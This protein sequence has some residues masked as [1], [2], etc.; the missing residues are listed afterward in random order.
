MSDSFVLLIWVADSKW[1]VSVLGAGP[2]PKPPCDCHGDNI[3]STCRRQVHGKHHWTEGFRATATQNVS[4][5][6]VLVELRG[7]V[8][9]WELAYLAT[10]SSGRQIHWSP[11]GG[12]PL[13]PTG[14]PQLSSAQS[15][16]SGNNTLPKLPIPVPRAPAHRLVEFTEALWLFVQRSTWITE[17]DLET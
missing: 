17:A 4:C 2:H 13:P 16:V 10:L 8:C 14:A 3:M 7:A 12:Q 1:M 5:P 15:E 6:G 9:A 11:P